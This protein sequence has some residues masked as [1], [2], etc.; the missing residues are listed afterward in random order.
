M[1]LT[2]HTVGMLLN[3]RQIAD[4]HHNWRTDGSSDRGHMPGDNVTIDGN[5]ETE[6]KTMIRNAL[7]V[8]EALKHPEDQY[9]NKDAKG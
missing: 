6:I 1:Y 9:Q 2:F 3:N 8:F 5:G 7:V 4:P